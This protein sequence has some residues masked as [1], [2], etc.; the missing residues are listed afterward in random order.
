MHIAPVLWSATFF[1]QNTEN[2]KTKWVVIQKTAGTSIVIFRKICSH[3]IGI[4]ICIPQICLITILVARCTLADK[5]WNN[6]HSGRSC[7]YFTR[8]SKSSICPERI[9]VS[10]YHV[11]MFSYDG[12]KNT[13]FPSCSCYVSLMWFMGN[14]TFHSNDVTINMTIAVEQIKSQITKPHRS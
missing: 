9:R 6:L 10:G 7:H 1:Q 8:F 11:L 12:I 5:F 2:T 13:F 14:P 4:E 3:E